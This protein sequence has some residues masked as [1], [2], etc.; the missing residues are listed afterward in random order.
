MNLQETIHAA[1]KGAMRSKDQA[2]ITSLRLLLTA[3]KVREKEIC[4]SLRDDEI[5][6][7]ITSQIKQRREAIEQFHKG[8]REDLVQAEENELRVLQSYL[9]AQLSDEDLAAVI[10]GI[11]AEVN[12]VSAKDIGKV[13]K[14]AMAKLAGRA[15][16]RK[17]NALVKAKL[18]G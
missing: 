12:A 4:R 13:M 18:G 10:D 5:L 16:G 8:G 6:A 17:V 15:D 1:L 7:V 14:A 3:M 11:I 2:A 9:P